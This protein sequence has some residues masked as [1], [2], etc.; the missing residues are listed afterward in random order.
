[1][2]AYKVIWMRI[3]KEVTHQSVATTKVAVTMV[4]FFDWWAFFEL[5]AEANRDAAKG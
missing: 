1:V 5:E 4:E 3:A 2:D